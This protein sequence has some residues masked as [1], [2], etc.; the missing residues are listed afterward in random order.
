[1]SLYIDHKYAA[2]IG[3]RLDKFKRKN[4][5]TYN[6]RCPLCGDSKKSKTKARGFFY[7]RGNKISFYCH[8]C[9][10]SM[11]LGKFLEEY[12]APLFEQY[13][14]EKFK[15]HPK[16]KE[17][18]EFDFKPKFSEKIDAIDS[19][20]IGFFNYSPISDLDDKHFA[21]EY[22]EHRRIPKCYW[23]DIYFI[24]DFKVLVDRVEP[25]NNY[26]LKSE[27][28]R[29]VFPFRNREKELTAFQGRSFKNSGLRY[30]TIK[31]DKDAPKI[32]GLD[33]V[34]PNH[35][36]YVVEGV[37]D[38]LF[39]FNSIACAGSNLGS[40]DIPFFDDMVFIYDNQPRSK[41]IVQA[42]KKIVDLGKEICIWPTSPSK[43]E[44]INDMILAGKTS[45]NII[46][47]INA[48]SYKG[49]AAEIAI[50]EWKRC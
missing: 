5:K 47:I 42:M 16:E 46:D 15:D 36:V 13:I 32:F 48:N 49:L 28:S 33:R 1:L 31:V 29:I 30:I 14:F 21:K 43:K 45:E 7:V 26:G 11:P 19:N 35:R 38:S 20:T 41:E 37:I 12:D 24:D 34:A 44:D 25:G 18:Y 39:I 22:I 8:N 6:F 50:T 27:D 40:K 3:P 23:G 10:R 2:L 17:T 9:L 4:Q